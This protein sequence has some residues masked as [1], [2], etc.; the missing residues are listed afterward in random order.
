[1]EFRLR[2]NI[3]PP[4]QHIR[5]QDQL[6]LL[7]SCFA[8]GMGKLFKASKF[9][10]LINP[11]G[12][13]FNPLSIAQTLEHGLR[14]KVYQIGDVF[15]HEGLWYSW[16]HHGAWAREQRDDTVLALN[17]NQKKF[18][19]FVQGTDIVFIT[20]GSA[21]VYEYKQSG[22]V[23]ANCHRVA[24][25]AFTKRLLS[26]KEITDAWLAILDHEQMRGKRFV[27]T[28]SPVRYVRDGLIENN[29]SKA[30]L[31]QAVHELV[32]ERGAWYFP[33]YEIVM[34]E[35]RDYRFFTRDLV[36]PNEMAIDYVWERLLTVACDD[37]TR[38]IIREVTSLVQAAS[39]R[40][41]HP[42]SEEHLSFRK[43]Y[44]GKALQ[45]ATRYPFLDLSEEI[46]FFR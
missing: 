1:M 36:H 2:F 44:H 17:E 43:T 33:A 30:I 14:S 10:C 9:R 4:A 27:F 29:L 23:V 11:H 39:H 25:T 3:A 37:D 8:D 38:T 5:M 16:D 12:I 24:Q 42:N 40:P 46:R 15:D 22:Q 35:L 18:E 28:V 41:L 13:Q 26:V 32:R 7:G 34:D 19:S 31:L 20:F 21:H 6:L 45:L